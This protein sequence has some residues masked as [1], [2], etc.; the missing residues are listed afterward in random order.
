MRFAA[1][2]VFG[3]AGCASSGVVPT[4]PG[5]FLISKTSA[6]GAFVSG[7]SVKADLIKEADAFCARDG[8]TVQVLT[9]DAKNAIPFARMPSAEVN[10]RCVER[11]K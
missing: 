6:G 11:E 5:T 7:A 8:K 1:L 2:F 9:S 10:F 4:G 3:L